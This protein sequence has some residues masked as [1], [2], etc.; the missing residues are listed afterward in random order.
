MVV[1]N[2]GRVMSVDLLYNRFEDPLT[3]AFKVL[4]SNSRDSM[5]YDFREPSGTHAPRSLA[6][7]VHRGQQGE[8]TSVS[9]CR[10]TTYHNI[11]SIVYLQCLYTFCYYV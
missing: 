11:Y 5:I 8:W 3:K 2:G 7:A 10:H 1:V 6:C 9:S 4:V